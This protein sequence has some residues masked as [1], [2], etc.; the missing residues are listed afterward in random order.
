MTEGHTDG[1]MDGWMEGRTDGRGLPYVELV[2]GLGICCLSRLVILIDLLHLLTSALKMAACASETPATQPTAK[3]TK[4]PD[5]N[6]INNKSLLKFKT[7]RRSNTANLWC[8][9]WFL[10]TPAWCSASEKATMEECHASGTI[11]W[12][13]LISEQC[14]NQVKPFFLS[15]IYI[16]M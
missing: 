14:T 7:G 16:W 3:D 12:L 5:S 13:P 11:T 15:Q 1:W 2:S 10:Q 6:N 8:F 9:M 4:P